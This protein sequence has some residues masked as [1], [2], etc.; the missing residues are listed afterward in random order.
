MR[1]APRRFDIGAEQV[2][3]VVTLPAGAGGQTV[4]VLAHG[5]GSDMTAPLL[6]AYADR[7]A[8]AGF[9]TVRFNFAF[10]ERGRRA[11]DR[12]TEL[13]ACYRRVLASIRSDPEL[14]D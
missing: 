1:H 2:S 9:P 6:V 7:L 3:G 4:V 8:E 5:A 11:P 14:S 12:A 10:T 13:E